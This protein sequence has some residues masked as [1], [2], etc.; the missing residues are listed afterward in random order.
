[1][2]AS[3]KE[4]AARA[5]KGPWVANHKSVRLSDSIKLAHRG[6]WGAAPEAWSKI[7]AEKTANAQL[8]ARCSPEVLLAV[9]DVV[10]WAA[11]SSPPQSGL[12]VMAVQALALLDGQ[13]RTE[14]QP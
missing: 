2:N 3:L 12:R 11:K 1:M 13:S 7:D 10:E 6:P 4:L 8:I 9:Y 14:V 5:T